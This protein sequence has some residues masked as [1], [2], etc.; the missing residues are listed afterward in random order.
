MLAL[1]RQEVATTWTTWAP[2]QQHA[3]P[4]PL[5]AHACQLVSCACRN[6]SQERSL[7]LSSMSSSAAAASLSGTV[8]GLTV[9]SFREWLEAKFGDAGLATI[10]AQP[11][12]PREHAAVFMEHDIGYQS[13]I[14][15]RAY[16]RCASASACAM[17]RQYALD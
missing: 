8:T 7:A 13:L 1:H 2:Q 4:T 9:L 11:E 14:P 15:E 12:L 6:L 5:H 3:K 16:L 10:L 17:L